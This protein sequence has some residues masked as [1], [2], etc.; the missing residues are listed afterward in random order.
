MLKDIETA[1][2]HLET[3]QAIWDKMKSTLPNQEDIGGFGVSV[4][5]ITNT[6]E[7]D[8]ILVASIKSIT[9]SPLIWQAKKSTI[10]NQAKA[11]N[12]HLQKHQA[13]PT[14]L[15]NTIGSLCTWLWAIKTGVDQIISISNISESAIDD[16][17]IKVAEKYLLL[18]EIA[19]QADKSFGSIREYKDK[20]SELLN[21]LNEIKA[22][23]ESV[24]N[25]I[26]NKKSTIEGS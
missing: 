9:I 16:L 10:V 12:D 23:A 5:E 7:E 22:N 4:D 19:Q 26:A 1:I 13:D 20:S 6:L 14:Q 18:G 21:S 24:N 3:A 15:G 11:I 25:E 8:K 2:K 17:K